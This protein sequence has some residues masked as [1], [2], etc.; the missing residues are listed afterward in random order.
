M[1]ELLVDALLAV[2]LLSSVI[3]S[4]L[5]HRR[6]A[7]LRA[8]RGEIESF[9]GALAATTD[10]AEAAIGGLRSAGNTIGQELQAQEAAARRSIEQLNR[11]LDGG[12]RMIRRLEQLQQATVASPERGQRA[13]LSRAGPAERDRSPSAEPPARPAAAAP[14]T[15][16]IPDDV[17]RAL[18]A[19]R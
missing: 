19:L 4:A 17:M 16:H 14:K 10:R 3:W 18:Q 7:R 8:D 2:L 5:L 6:L 13:A 1:A 11:A 9:I 15:G 12:G